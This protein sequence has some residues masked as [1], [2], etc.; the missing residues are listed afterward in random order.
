MKKLYIK[1][2]LTVVVLVLG[3]IA[4]EAI[5]TDGFTLGDGEFELVIV[6]QSDQIVYEETLTYKEGQSFFDVLKEN[7]EITCAN[8]YY[9]E[10]PTCSYTF[11]VMSVK[12]HVILGI[13]SDT[14]EIMTNWNHSFIKIEVFNGQTYAQTNVGFD[15]VDLES[16][17]KIRL[18][19]DLVE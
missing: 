13:K 16:N 17:K 11:N 9:K 14:F 19:A 7:F 8:K 1:I 5:M 18:T 10:D 3:Y 4:I 2:I 6:D 15:H 12:S